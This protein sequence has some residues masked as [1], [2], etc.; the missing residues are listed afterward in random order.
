M[1]DTNKT[2]LLEIIT[3]QSADGFNKSPDIY[4]IAYELKSVEIARQALQRELGCI[5][6][7]GTNNV[8]WITWDTHALEVKYN[9]KGAGENTIRSTVRMR[10]LSGSE[11][12]KVECLEI[13]G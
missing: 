12:G 8:E 4:R 10:I 11:N 2:F 7:C 6:R 5:L 9:N 3:A 1:E 13:G